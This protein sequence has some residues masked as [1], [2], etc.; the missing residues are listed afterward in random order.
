M[1]IFRVLISKV[2]ISRVLLTAP[3]AKGPV[4]RE[5]QVGSARNEAH[6][7][8]GPQRLSINLAARHAGN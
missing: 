5:P 7:R 6:G 1:L 2:L 8:E 3:T 4:T